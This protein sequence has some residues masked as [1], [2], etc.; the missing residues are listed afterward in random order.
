[1]HE[2][3]KLY[4]RKFEAHIDARILDLLNEAAYLSDEQ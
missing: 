1:M 4:A 2:R 3:L